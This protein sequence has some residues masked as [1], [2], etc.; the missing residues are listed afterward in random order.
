MTDQTVNS[1]WRGKL[2]A[3]ALTFSILTALWFAVAALGSK[4]GWWGWQFG[5]LKMIAG[6]GPKLIFVALGLGVVA[7]IAAVIRAPRTKPVLLALAALLVSIM[8]LGRLMAFGA[9]SQ[10]VPPIHD[11]ST[12]WDD[13]VMF[14]EKLMAL[15]QADG[16]L[17]AV[18]FAP[19]IPEA[20]NERW[21]GFGGRLVSQVQEEAELDP[22][23]ST[24][25]TPPFPQLDTITV[26]G[27]MDSVT[28]AAMALV[29]DYGWEIVSVPITGGDEAIIEATE[30]STWFGF[31]DDIAIRL[32]RAGDSTEV[33]VRSVSR[34]GFTDLGKNAARVGTFLYDLEKGPH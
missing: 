20:A 29:R 12:N 3:V 27:D 22:T 34:V 1:G 10:S 19:V 6:W 23:V 5:L 24:E 30:T 2:A 28:A 11:I 8:M 15:R 17:N 13:P 4:F 14:S 9:L 18:E 33:D 31:R 7:L 32:R 25:E 26:N 16:A 21:P